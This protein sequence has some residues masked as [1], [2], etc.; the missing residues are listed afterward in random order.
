[1]LSRP[2]F[3][4]FV[5]AVCGPAEPTLGPPPT[6]AAPSTASTATTPGDTMNIDNLEIESPLVE[7]WLTYAVRVPETGFVPRSKVPK[8]VREPVVQSKAISGFFYK[9]DFNPHRQAEAVEWSV[10]AA[11]RGGVDLLRARYEA[12][13]LELE[14]L[15]GRTFVL[16]Q[17]KARDADTVFSHGRRAH[18][19]VL[20]GRLVELST[21]SHTWTIHL[22]DEVD[23]LSRT[24]VVSNEG[25]PAVSDL[26]DHN[27]RMD[28]LIEG[29]STG[30]LFYKR[31]G[32]REDFEPADAWFSQTDRTELLKLQSRQSP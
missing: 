31:I 18:V 6:P 21:W 1:M 14:V 15:E 10:H 3:L 11:S 30:F 2:L 28:V 13:G 29:N 22:P 32:Q 17:A 25:A 19:T 26:H 9:P 16:L 5:L 7:S 24:F 27:D 12:Q 8:L 23:D 4:G 20:L